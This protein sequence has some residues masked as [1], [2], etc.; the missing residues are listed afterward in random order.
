MGKVSEN[1]MIDLMTQMGEMESTDA[2]TVTV[3]KHAF[4]DDYE[5]DLDNLDL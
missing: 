2:T 5:V 4:E 1:Q 3:A